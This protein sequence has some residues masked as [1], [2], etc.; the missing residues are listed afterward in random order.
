MKPLLSREV[1]DLIGEL[2]YDYNKNLDDKSEIMIVKQAT[3]ELQDMFDKGLV[4]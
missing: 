2:L 3:E 1:Y 4:L